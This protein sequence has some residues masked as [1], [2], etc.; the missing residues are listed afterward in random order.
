MRKKPNRLKELCG[1]ARL[2]RIPVDVPPGIPNKPSFSDK[3]AG[4]TWDLLTSELY[5]AGILSKLDASI[6]ETA[7]L[8][9]SRIKAV[10]ETLRIQGE[11]ITDSGGNSKLNP[12]AKCLKDYCSTFD[13][14]CN[15]LALTP[16]ARSK[17]GLEVKKNEPNESDFFL[18]GFKLRNQIRGG[19][20]E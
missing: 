9:F 8:L 16:Q 1:T 2:D 19:S 3:I 11:L 20:N 12:L 10:V 14:L 15:S 7:C 13:T 6:L 18:Q 5:Q 4:D 17:M